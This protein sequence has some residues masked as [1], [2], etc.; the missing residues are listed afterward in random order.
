MTAVISN[1]PETINF[2]IQQGVTLAFTLTWATQPSKEDAEAVA[3]YIQDTAPLSGMTTGNKWYDSTGGVLY[4]Y[5]GS[6]WVVDGLIDLTGCTASLNFKTA[7][8]DVANL[9][10]MTTANSKL[11]LGGVAGTISGKI[12]DEDSAA[13]DFTKAVCK[14]L[15]NFNNGD[16]FCVSKGS[17]S[18]IV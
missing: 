10:S 3:N 18:V 2:E 5:N 6:A 13:F 8:T 17:V 12:A 11:T 14:L 9:Y 1:K 4:E 7:H 15:V 16:V